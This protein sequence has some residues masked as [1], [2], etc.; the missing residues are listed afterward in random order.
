MTMVECGRQQDRHTERKRVSLP[1]CDCGV[2]VVWYWYPDRNAKLVRCADCAAKLWQ[3]I[4][5]RMLH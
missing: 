1:C 3:A 5:R 2:R 4:R